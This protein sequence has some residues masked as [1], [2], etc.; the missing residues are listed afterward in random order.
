MGCMRKNDLFFRGLEAKLMDAW[1]LSESDRFD[2]GL[3]CLEIGGEEKSGA[4]RGVFFLCVVSFSDVESG[5]GMKET[6]R[7]FSEVAQERHSE[8]E[9][10]RVE[11]GEELRGI[12]DE[13]VIGGSESGS[14]NYDGF[15]AMQKGL[16]A[17]LKILSKGNV[18]VEIDRSVVE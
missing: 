11:D 13:L 9:V 3:L 2:A 1:S 6:G 5:V 17:I 16:E 7:L 15:V 12:F 8:A 4:A 18:D 14:A 10:G